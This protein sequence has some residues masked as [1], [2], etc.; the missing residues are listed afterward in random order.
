MPQRPTPRQ[1]ATILSPDLV[2]EPWTPVFTGAVSPGMSRADVIAVWG[3]PVAEGAAGTWEY[4]Y[5]RNGCEVTC[6]TFDVVM[7]EVGQVVDA[8]VRGPGHTYTGV[9][10]SPPGRE[11]LLTLPSQ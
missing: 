4:L 11:P 1:Q 7:L 6:G 10:S 3:E 2:D 8:I 9:S 5:F